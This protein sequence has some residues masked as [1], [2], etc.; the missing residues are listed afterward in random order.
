MNIFNIFTL[1]G[2][3]ALFLFGMEAMGDGLKKLSGSK[4]EKILG[5][6][7]SNPFKAV[8]LGTG[9]TAIIQSSSATT[10]MVVGFVNSGIMGLNQAVGIIMGANI[11]TTVTSWLLS[12]TG[13]NGSNFFIQML[14]P[15]SFSPIL[16]FVG[17]VFLMFCKSEKKQDLGTILLGFYVLMT[18]M[19]IMS[20][21]VA[22]L[23]EMPEFTKLM[24]LFDNPILGMLVGAIMTA[25]IQSS[26]A[27]VGILQAL[28]MTGT[29]PYGVAIPII[30]G[31]NI[32]TCITAILSAI[33]ANRNSKRASLIH[34]YFNLIGTT[35]F[36]IAFYTSN[37]FVHYDFLH[38]AANAV[39]IATIH[40]GFNITATLL[41]LPFSKKLVS[42][43]YLTLP[44]KPEEERKES[45][46]LHLLDDRFLEKPS[47]ALSQ[48]TD[49]AKL[50]M[51]ELQ[52]LL[53]LKKEEEDSYQIIN[54][55]KMQKTY[56]NLDK[57]ISALND[58]LMK[59]SA[60]P[61]SHSDNYFINHLLQGIGELKG[62]SSHIFH[63]GTIDEKMTVKQ[64]Q[65]SS[66]A[67]IEMRELLNTFHSAM[68]QIIYFIEVPNDY[69]CEEGNSKLMEIRKL[70]KERRKNH[71]NRLKEGTCTIDV[72]M[73]Y[74]DILS[75]CEQ[76]STHCT[77][78]L[79]QMEDL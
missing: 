54:Y 65:L 42:L 29:V 79:E 8:L 48:A 39:G 77:N 44:L 76:I 12:M 57:E 5:H 59:I 47:F 61:L 43:S 66:K 53:L 62:I 36:M 74:I 40:S 16:A 22:P 32:G 51:K 55:N 50:I 2:G 46:V 14:E 13:I 49:V 10:V 26:S 75:H 3:L 30:M 71:I 17:I 38:T 70:I 19:E 11:G 24:T 28:C 56:N 60:Y 73:F 37:L 63:I 4:L 45:P 25:V 18:G 78:L 52:E 68:E 1:L 9:V 41:L 69:Q 7:T 23:A 72:G 21:S 35:I 27:S 34:L 67:K 15:S 58:Y 20:G 33:G 31:Q 64:Q 6:L